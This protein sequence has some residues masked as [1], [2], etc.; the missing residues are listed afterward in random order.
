MC[1]CNFLTIFII[2]YMKYFIY[3]SVI[4]YYQYY[5]NY[6]ITIYK[7]IIKYFID[8]FLLF[9]LVLKNRILPLVN[10]I[11]HPEKFI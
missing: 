4:N 6:Y 9:Y 7:V 1:L 8:S 2:D 10:N 3:N 11:V 5:N